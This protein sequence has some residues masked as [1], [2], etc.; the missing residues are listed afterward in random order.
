M[1]S[2]HRRSETS[3]GTVRSGRLRLSKPSGCRD[4]TLRNLSHLQTVPARHPG[5]PSFET[6]PD[7]GQEISAEPTGGGAPVNRGISPEFVWRIADASRGSGGLWDPTAETWLV[8][9][10]PLAQG[11]LQRDSW[12][13]LRIHVIAGQSAATMNGW[14]AFRHETQSGGREFSRVV[15]V[16]G[17]DLPATVRFRNLRLR[18]ISEDKLTADGS[19]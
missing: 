9:D 14:E 4:N 18:E 11:S 17:G 1:N 13:D 19:L 2:K 12:N 15:L 5:P 6:Q 7:V 3:P 10:S 8:G 16:A